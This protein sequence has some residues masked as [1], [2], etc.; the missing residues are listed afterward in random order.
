M[1]VLSENGV[2]FVYHYAPLHYLPF[3]ARSNK[4]MSK[5][6]L[7][8]AGFANTHFRSKSKN[9][10][11]KRG[12]GDF[13]HLTTS[14]HPNILKA[15]LSAGFPHICI[16][17]NSDY[18]D[19]HDYLLCRYNIAM[20]RQLRKDD[21]PGFKESPHN[22][23]YYGDMQIPVAKSQN[24]KQSMLSHHVPKGTMIE[25]LIKNEIILPPNTIITCFSVEDQRIVNQL[26]EKYEL[27]W[28]CNRVDAPHYSRCSSHATNVSAFVKKAIEREDW[29]GDGL[30]FD[31]FKNYSTKRPDCSG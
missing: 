6:R 24:E 7:L 22:G 25:I 15:K 2:S 29:L 18:I 1:A 31:K 9:L 16:Q 26:L 21:K 30:E 8:E 5:P 23:A 27:N 10:D 3:I 28:S 13:L 17:M 4:L 19:E 14:S 20:T 11:S 12:F